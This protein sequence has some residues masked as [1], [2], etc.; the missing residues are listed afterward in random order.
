MNLILDCD[1]WETFEEDLVL[2]PTPRPLPK[3]LL[4]ELRVIQHAFRKRA[5]KKAFPSFTISVYDSAFNWRGSQQGR[6]GDNY[7][8]TDELKVAE[9]FCSV[10]PSKMKLKSIQKELRN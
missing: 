1:G 4:R 6:W 2:T 9:D 8:T 7:H 10:Q 5:V 3:P